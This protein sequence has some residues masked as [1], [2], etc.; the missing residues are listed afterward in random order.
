M[1]VIEI[2]IYKDAYMHNWDYSAGVAQ[3]RLG[4][5]LKKWEPAWIKFNMVIWLDDEINRELYGND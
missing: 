1:A 4:L 5:D 3:Y 2:T